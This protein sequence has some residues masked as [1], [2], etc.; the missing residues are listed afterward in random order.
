MTA[1]LLLHVLIN[2][3]FN[4]NFISLGYLNVIVIFH[5]LS[6]N[7]HIALDTHSCLSSCGFNLHDL[8]KVV[9]DPN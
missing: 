2:K 4:S 5:S 8:K 7:I 9:N 1:V 3:H 6:C